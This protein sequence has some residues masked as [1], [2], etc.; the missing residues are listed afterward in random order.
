[1][2][3]LRDATS[4]LSGQERLD[5]IQE[6]AE[7]VYESLS[8]AIEE[9]EQDAEKNPR[10]FLGVALYPDRLWSWFITIATLGFG[11]LQKTLKK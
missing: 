11:F 6:I 2:K 10:R 3:L 4:D 7:K 5:R 9:L 1:M 8:D